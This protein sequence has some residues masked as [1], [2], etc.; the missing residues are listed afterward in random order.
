MT[1]A[2]LSSS[3]TMTMTTVRSKTLV[4]EAR[5]RASSLSQTR[6]RLMILVRAILSVLEAAGQSLAQHQD[7]CRARWRLSEFQGLPLLAMRKKDSQGLLSSPPL[8][9]HDWA[10]E[11]SMIEATSGIL[12]SPGINMFKRFDTHLWQAH[13]RRPSATNDCTCTA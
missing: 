8:R 6:R 1:F 4:L 13:S 10:S 2:R 11:A 12:R 5:L 3:M 7:R 9:N